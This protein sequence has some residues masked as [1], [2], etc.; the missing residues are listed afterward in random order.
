MLP[1]TTDRL[2]NVER[3]RFSSCR[4]QEAGADCVLDSRAIVPLANN[5]KLESITAAWPDG[6]GR[7]ANW[8]P[9]VIGPDCTGDDLSFQAALTELNLSL[10]HI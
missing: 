7:Y 8:N 1:P 3:Y 2:E 10:I 9:D 5:Q 4:A 6:A